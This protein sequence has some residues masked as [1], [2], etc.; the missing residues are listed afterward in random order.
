M[1]GG[2]GSGALLLGAEG[3]GLALC[4]PRGQVFGLG[5]ALEEI[6]NIR[7][8]F[9][10]GDQHRVIDVPALLP[11]RIEDDLFPS[12]I[13]MKGG[14]NTGSRIVE[15]DRAHADRYVKLEAVS[16]GKKWFELAD[17]IAFIIEHRPAAADPARAEVVRRHLR[18]AIRPNDDL[19]VCIAPGHRPSLCL[20][21]LLDLP[22]E[23]V[24]VREAVLNLC[25]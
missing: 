16:V 18:L 13:W 19:P 7:V 8:G 15:E 24:G 23:A 9:G 3:S 25:L 21:L 1:D 4:I 14:D 22:A 11:P 2:L 17:R 20:D 6:S 5:Q 10:I 12:V